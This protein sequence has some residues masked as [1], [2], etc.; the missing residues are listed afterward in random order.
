MFGAF[1]LGIE[2]AGDIQPVVNR[3]MA[4]N[5]VLEGD[6]NGNGILDVDDVKITLELA[7]GYR[8]PAPQELAADP[9]HDYVITVEDALTILDTLKRLP[10]TP[11]VQL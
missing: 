7:K 1:L 4:G 11:K 5:A 3:T 2:T 9:D 8:T 6:M 10:G